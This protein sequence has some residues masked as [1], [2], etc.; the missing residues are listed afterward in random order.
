MV[1]AVFAT[2]STWDLAKLFSSLVG[3]WTLTDLP[4]PFVSSHL[5]G[6]DSPESAAKELGQIFEGWDQSWWIEQRRKEP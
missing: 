3:S 5:A 1:L 4:Y 6:S 2:I